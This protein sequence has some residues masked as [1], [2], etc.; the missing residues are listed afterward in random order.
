M[1]EVIF[2]SNKG[3]IFE[4]TTPSNGGKTVVRVKNKDNNFLHKKYVFKSGVEELKS[5]YIS[6][7]NL[8]CCNGWTY[9]EEYLLTAVQKGKKLCSGLTFDTEDECNDYISKI[10]DDFLYRAFT[11]NGWS[12]TFYHVDI[13][14]KGSIQDYIGA[15][16][17]LCKY[18]ELN[19]ENISTK[20]VRK[21][22]SKPMIELISE[23][24]DYANPC[25]IEEY[26][27]TGLLLGYPLESTAGLVSF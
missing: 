18:K 23:T 9:D 17:V 3:I 27:A 25:S 14:R 7:E 19:V 1:K 21:L 16:E 8:N 5:P 22:L 11:T 12:I 10:T 24:F 15:K 4:K 2:E 6:W 26:I 20:K 13:V